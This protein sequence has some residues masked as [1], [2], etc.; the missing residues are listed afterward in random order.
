VA[1]VQIRGDSIF[2]LP[3]E[4][5]RPFLPASIAALRKQLPG[6]RAAMN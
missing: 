5:A 4:I 1:D 2:I 3:G 6:S